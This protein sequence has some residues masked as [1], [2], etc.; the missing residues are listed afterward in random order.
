MLF[1][2]NS[3]AFSDLGKY[4]QAPRK[5]FSFPDDKKLLHVS[6][7]I[8]H[9]HR[10]P[11][12]PQL[13]MSARGHWE[14]DDA[15]APA[16]RSEGGPSKFYRYYDQILDPEMIDYPPSC[17]AGDLTIVGQQMHIDLGAAYRK[18]LVDEKHFLPQ[19][20]DP[21]LF[22]FYTSPIERTFRS[23]ES[24]IDGLYPPLS[25]NE[26]LTIISGTAAAAPLNPSETNCEQM[27]VERDAFLASD[28]YKNLVTGIWPDIKDATQQ[29]FH[30]ME[31][32]VDGVHLICGWAVAFNCSVGSQVPVFM[33]DK[34]MNACRKEN[35][36]SQWGLFAYL[37]NHSV[38]GAPI[39][40]HILKVAEDGMKSGK[41]FALQSAHDTTL[42][43]FLTYLGVP[44]ED[45][46]PYAS[47]V[48]ITFWEDNSQ[49]KYIKISLNGN[50]L[51]MPGFEGS[52]YVEYSQF[53]AKYNQFQDFCPEIAV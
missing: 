7:L 8:R 17:R 11:E 9:G 23:A 21:A 46:T 10:T 19:K 29:Y 28:D 27:K 24:F 35:R 51:I 1:F 22:D 49:N 33:D 5:S 30:V 50:D 43:A 16:P 40:R 13:P 39:Y 18:F 15:N 47:H 38:A 34:F 3:L 42:A 53:R 26:V 37:S 4:C 2:L 36:Y 32:T 45:V 52:P 31:P 44:Q 6:V 48:A 41:K 20:M 12:K 25:D 14:C